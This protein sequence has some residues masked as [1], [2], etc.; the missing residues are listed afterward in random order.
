MRNSIVILLLFLP[1]LLCAQTVK[2]LQ[3]Q[4]QQTLKQLE[5]TGKMLKETKRDESATQNKLAIITNDI[6]QRKKL[7][8]NI[9]AEIRGLDREMTLLQRRLDSLERELKAARDDYANL[10]RTT[11]YTNNQQSTIRFLFSAKNF[12][13]FVRRMYYMQQFSQYRKQQVENIEQISEKINKQRQDVQDNR[14]QKLEARQ[15]QQR[16]R[17]KLARDEK[18]HQKMLDNLKSKEKQL[19]AQQKKQ[20]KKADELNK[21]IEKKIAEEQ[22]KAS[23]QK[24]TAEQQLVA[25]GFEK[26]KG[27]LPWPAD[28]GFVSGKFGKQAHPV[29]K[30]VTVVNKGVM[31]QTTAGTSA[32]AVYEGEVTSCFSD[33]MTNNVIIKHGNYYTVYAGLSK[34]L[35]KAG[36]KVKAKQDIG[37]IYSDPDNDNKTELEF[38]IYKE[39]DLLDPTNWL[40][41]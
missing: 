25:G 19:L 8:G 29:L 39:K 10:V 33:G 20:Q 18:K 36:T 15:V 32:R 13:Q 38:R 3:K 23:K 14:K 24:L 5:T 16:E 4:R 11:H 30:G 2:E 34:L 27:R 31:N 6:S 17:D 41:K 40:S 12:N 1:F 9:N 35:V 28:N 7:I 22:K 26:N 21:Q 37:T